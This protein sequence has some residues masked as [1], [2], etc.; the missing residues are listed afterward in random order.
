MPASAF[1]QTWPLPGLQEF[2][3][4]VRGAQSQPAGQHSGQTLEPDE[5]AFVS[6]VEMKNCDSVCGQKVTAVDGHQR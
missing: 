1:L 3:V 6:G 2:R 4:T 5:G